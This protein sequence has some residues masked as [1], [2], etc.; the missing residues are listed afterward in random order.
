MKIQVDAQISP[1][2]ALWINQNFD[3]IIAE[4]VRSIGLRDAS[5]KLIFK[6]AEKENA[7][8]MSKDSDFL[9]LIKNKNSTV[10]FVWITCGNTSNIKLK[11]VL[12]K[13]LPE[14]KKLL[15]S[16]E[17]IVEISDK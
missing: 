12:S 5:D 4:S 9:N 6:K 7:I 10:Q 17:Q 8:I 16:G 11:D 2:I 14:V 15:Q 3:D 1:T 13:T